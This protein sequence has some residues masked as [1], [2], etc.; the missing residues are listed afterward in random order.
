MARPK[1]LSK[2]HIE[3][4]GDRV[5]V[6]IANGVSITARKPS[7]GQNIKKLAYKTARLNQVTRQFRSLQ[8]ALTSIVI[9]N[10]GG[11]VGGSGTDVNIQKIR[12]DLTDAEIQA[13][14]TPRLQEDVKALVGKLT[15]L[16]RA[17]VSVKKNIDTNL[18]AIDAKRIVAANR[19]KAQLN[20]AKTPQARASI[21]SLGVQ[22]AGRV[23]QAAAMV[24]SQGDAD[25]SRLSKDYET[26]QATLR[27]KQNELDGAL[28][29]LR[30]AAILR[31]Q[32]SSTRKSGV[33]LKRRRKILTVN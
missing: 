2:A 18:R 17:L 27:E 7:E 21:L 8:D 15:N 30:K 13:S 10:R 28:Q 16:E 33:R 3:R 19:L 22:A 6:D 12:S 11:V 29:S 32:L 5:L 31:K 1:H 25:Y 24:R 23:N 14:E 20:A 4:R 9:G 26:I